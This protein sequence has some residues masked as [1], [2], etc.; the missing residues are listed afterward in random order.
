M[1]SLQVLELDLTVSSH[2][3]IKWFNL[4]VTMPNLQTIYIQEFC[5]GSCEVEFHGMNEDE[6]LFLY[7]SEALSCFQ[8]SLFTIHFGVP[9]NRFILRLPNERG[10]SAERLLLSASE[11]PVTTG[12][13]R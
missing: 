6:D 12:E 2:S 5:C 1:N 7:L 11:P 10:I 13:Q 8:S 9:L 3:A 4:P